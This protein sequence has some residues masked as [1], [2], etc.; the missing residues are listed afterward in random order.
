VEI[1]WIGWIGCLS[2]A[3]SAQLPRLWRRPE[4]TGIGLVIVID[5]QQVVDVARPSNFGLTDVTA[6]A[7]P[8]AATG[9]KAVQPAGAAH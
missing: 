6:A 5:G 9:S 8:A 1:V 4:P 3:V 2:M 7:G